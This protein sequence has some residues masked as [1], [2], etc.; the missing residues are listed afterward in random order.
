MSEVEALYQATVALAESLQSDVAYAVNR[1]D[2]IR[3]S[4]RASEA[5][6]LVNML[7][8]LIT[9]PVAPFTVTH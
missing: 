8:H 2:Q 3:R 1:E 4:I 9:P 6:G 7:N 5:V